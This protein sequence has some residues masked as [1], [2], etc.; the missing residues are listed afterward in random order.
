[1][2]VRAVQVS[3]RF[4]PMLAVDGVDVVQEGP[5]VLGV[6]GPNGSGKST[7]LRLMAG[8]VVPALGECFLEGEPAQRYV[9]RPECPVGFVP[10]APPLF[11]EMKTGSYLRFL[12]RLRDLPGAS[13]PAAVEAVIGD[14]GLGEVLD[15]EVGNLSKGFQQRVNLAQ[16]FLHR[17]RY[18]FLD[19]PTSG[20]DPVAC[21]AIRAVIQHR[22][23]ESLILIS[24]HSFAEIEVLASRAIILVDGRL[25]ADSGTEAPLPG[26]LER[27]YRDALTHGDGA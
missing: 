19:E 21:D 4:G 20:L 22:A 9:A 12:A 7:L 25:A 3:H 15:Q 2:S 6:L 1:M 24:S 5:G 27:L 14:F 18:L 13:R 26:R 16:G 10:E 8:L 11:P 23:R 17:P